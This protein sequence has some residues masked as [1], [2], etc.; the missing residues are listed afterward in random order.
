[1]LQSGPN[2][3]SLTGQV[4]NRGVDNNPTLYYIDTMTTNTAAETTKICFRCKGSGI[5]PAHEN[6]ADG[7]C[8]TCEGTGL[9]LRKVD[10]PKVV[11][12]NGTTIT[13]TDN[14]SHYAVLV[15]TGDAS[16]RQDFTNLADA[17][18]AA[19]TAYRTAKEA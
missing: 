6:V 14:R 4:A 7:Q 19:N 11:E 18:A 12:I 17:K 5:L 10:A 16:T 13:L 8:F 2:L 3:L 15:R 9:K 1:M